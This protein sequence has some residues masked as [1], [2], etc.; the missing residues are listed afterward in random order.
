ML[1]LAVIFALAG[2]AS[3]PDMHES[4]PVADTRPISSVIVEVDSTFY[5][6]YAAHGG[7]SVYPAELASKLS[8]LARNAGEQSTPITLNALQIDQ[9]AGRTIVALK[10]SHLLRLRAISETGPRD[11]PP[12]SFMW[13]VD[14]LQQQPRTPVSSLQYDV[15]PQNTV[16][17]RL[18]YRAQVNAPACNSMFD[19]ESSLSHCADDLAATIEKHLYARGFVA[20]AEP[21]T[22]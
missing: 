19:S 2:C 3:E 17:Y 8:E 21:Q 10:P 11:A 1:P 9:Q 12:D 15:T 16:R 4:P 5:D 18:V 20:G 6:N 7:A 13:Q 22:N 14:L